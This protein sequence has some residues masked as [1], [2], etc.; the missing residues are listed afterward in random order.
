MPQ[1]PAERADEPLPVSLEPTLR[2]PGQ[3]RAR[4]RAV[5]A[6]APPGTLDTAVLLV[7]ELVTNAVLHGN[8]VITLSVDCDPTGVHACVADG[9]RW[10]GSPA[11][12]PAAD[13]SAE[14]GRGLCLVA[15]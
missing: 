11:A 2:A 15:P 9:G 6:Q 4:V 12:P 10:D 5:C 8:G 1:Q 7:S 14:R 3:A 13:P